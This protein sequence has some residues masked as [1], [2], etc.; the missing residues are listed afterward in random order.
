LAALIENRAGDDWDR[1]EAEKRGEEDILR[2]P[3]EFQVGYT[4]LPI[5]ISA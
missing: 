1:Y 5:A 4:R 2:P 3:S